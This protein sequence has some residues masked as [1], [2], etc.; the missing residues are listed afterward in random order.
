MSDRFEINPLGQPVGNIVASWTPARR[1]VDLQLGGHWCALEHLDAGRHLQEIY[2]ANALDVSGAMWTYLPYGPFKSLAEYGAWMHSV[3]N[4]KDLLPVAIID[5]KLGRAVGVGAYLRM[6][7]L[8]GSIEIGHLSFSP[9]LQRTRAS[10]EAMYLMMDRAFELGYRRCEW[11]CDALNAPSRSAAC[12]LGF[13]FEGIFRQATIVKGRNRDT[14]WYAV[15]DSDWPRIQVAFR[16]WLN[17]TNFNEE[18]RQ[19]TRLSQLTGSTSS[20]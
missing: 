1:P 7:E 3:T 20:E 9:L 4:N 14:A 12:R 16:R 10:T 8:N 5:V 18:G 13:T 6:D 19:L 11:K 2:T 17:P 15:I